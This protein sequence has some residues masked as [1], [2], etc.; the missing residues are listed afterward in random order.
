[1]K[2]LFNIYL[3]LFAS[4]LFIAACNDSDEEGITGFT[5]DTQEVTLGATGGIGADKMWL[6]VPNG[7]QR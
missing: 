6:Q 4:L 5:I 1:M 2:P 3:C 7:W